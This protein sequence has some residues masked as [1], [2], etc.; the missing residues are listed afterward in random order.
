MLPVPS[1]PTWASSPYRPA[2]RMPNGKPGD[3]PL[4]DSVV[5]R[6]PTY[7]P[8]I[9][10]LIRAI[11]ALAPSDDTL[12]RLLWDRY[13]FYPRGSDDELRRD[14]LALREHLLRLPKLRD[15]D[16][17]RPPNDA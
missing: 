17:S 11:H 9:D 16:P 3:H 10:A 14:L 4:T 5:H 2:H 12:A 13:T 1:M 15:Q 6:I 8:D 7:T